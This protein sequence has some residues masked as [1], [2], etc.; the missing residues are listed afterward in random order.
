M[1]A[2]EE[3]LRNKIHQFLDAFL[4]SE[5]ETDHNEIKEIFGDEIEKYFEKL[6]ADELNACGA[7]EIEDLVFDLMIKIEKK[8]FINEKLEDF[9]EKKTEMFIKNLDFK[10]KCKGRK[11]GAFL[12]ELEEDVL[13]S[14][15]LRII[16][17]KRKREDSEDSWC[18][19]ELS[20]DD[21]GS[22][23]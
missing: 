8:Y 15:L 13:E 22:N 6:N 9:I 18:E 21:D 16:S 1:S 2:W 12:A 23:K 11:I 7:D 5:L 14:D 20:D 3:N 17:D 4:D 19:S 10:G